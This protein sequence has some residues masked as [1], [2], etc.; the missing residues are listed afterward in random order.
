MPTDVTSPP[1]FGRDARLDRRQALG[2]PRLPGAP[3]LR[4]QLPLDGRRVVVD[5]GHVLDR[6]LRDEHQLAWRGGRPRRQLLGVVEQRVVVDAAP[7]EPDPLGLGAVEHLAEHHRRHHRLRPGDAPKHPR[8]AAA[9]VQP[10][11]QEPGVELGPAGG[12]AHVAPERQVHPGADGRAVD[13]GQRR[14]R[15]AGDA[16]EPLV[17]VAEARAVGRPQVAEVGAGAEGRRRPG[18]DERADRLVTLDLVHR[19]RDV[20]DHRGGEGVA[21]L[22]V[23]ERQGGDAVTD[24]GADQCHAR[25]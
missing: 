5:V 25:F 23:I 12:E 7:H 11:L 4:L 18:D 3:D 24:V 17:D 6:R 20:G 8:V 2:E 14:Q 9:R 16:Q 19:R 13:G 15:A 10:E 21:L 1:D 22:G